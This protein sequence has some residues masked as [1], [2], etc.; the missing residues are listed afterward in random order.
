MYYKRDEYFMPKSI[1]DILIEPTKT[2][3]DGEVNPDVVV[4]TDHL[5]LQHYGSNYSTADDGRIAVIGNTGGLITNVD[6]LN[7]SVDI[8]VN[9][10]AFVDDTISPLY[11]K[12]RFTGAT[13]FHSPCRDYFCDGGSNPPN[14][15]DDYVVRN[16]SVVKY[17]FT[18]KTVRHGYT[19]SLVMNDFEISVSVALPKGI[20]NTMLKR[21]I[22]SSDIALLAVV[23]PEDKSLRI[24]YNTFSRQGVDALSPL[25][26]RAKYKSGSI[27]YDKRLSRTM[28]EFY[29]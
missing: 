27:K 23:T 7:G 29:I 2:I 18:P 3:V 13:L 5:L 8:K 25:V 17:S 4:M 19:D 24:D 20:D 14:C 11:I 26:R 9:K 15:N 6:T 1:I 10:G 12:E 21:T 16:C 22:Y 28:L